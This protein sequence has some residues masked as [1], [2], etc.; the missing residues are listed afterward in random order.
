MKRTYIRPKFTVIDM[1]IE[2]VIASS[3]NPD[4]TIELDSE[5]NTV[6]GNNVLTNKHDWN[7]QA[8][9]MSDNQE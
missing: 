6:G 1:K 4:N 3:P 2:Q 9:N 5:N 8:W 7:R